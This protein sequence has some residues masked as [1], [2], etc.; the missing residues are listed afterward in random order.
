MCSFCFGQPVGWLCCS[1]GKQ[2]GDDEEVWAEG[3]ERGNFNVVRFTHVEF[4]E[5]VGYP[6]GNLSVVLRPR[7]E[8]LVSR[9]SLESHKHIDGNRTCVQEGLPREEGILR[10][11]QRTTQI[12][13]RLVQT[14]RSA[15]PPSLRE[16]VPITVPGGTSSHPPHCTRITVS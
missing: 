9:H 5:A 13:Q 6:E 1:L 15:K 14:Q 11:K 8:V 2:I 16:A 7:Q 10:V 3:G 4:E 12:N